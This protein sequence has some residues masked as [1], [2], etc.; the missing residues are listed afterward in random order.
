MGLRELDEQTAAQLAALV[1]LLKTR[2]LDVKRAAYELEAAE[3]RA[4]VPAGLRLEH[5]ADSGEEDVDQRREQHAK[6]NEADLGGDQAARLREVRR[7][8]E[9]GAARAFVGASLGKG[10]LAAG[11]A[12]RATHRGRV[13][14]RH[15]V[16]AGPADA[17]SGV[18]ELA[19]RADGDHRG[20]TRRCKG[21]HRPVGC[22]LQC[23]KGVDHAVAE[24]VVD[25]LVADVFARLLQDAPGL[26][27]REVRVGAPDQAEQAGRESGRVGRAADRTIGAVELGG[28]QRHTG[29]DDVH[30][31]SIRR[32]VRQLTVLAADGAHDD[33]VILVPVAP[34]ELG[35]RVPRGHHK[36]A[37]LA[38]DVRGDVPPL[39]RGGL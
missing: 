2:V 28:E 16:A 27:G 17:A 3:R 37:A 19:G 4:P 13:R 34:V 26:V 15:A 9:P 24:H 36:Q 6:H 11:R 32:L 25:P 14:P 22:Q 39:G 38:L 35:V 7:H 20:R 23:P 18:Q 31:P 1:D 21:A 10:A 33:D 12:P 29:R 30:G 8:E 5:H